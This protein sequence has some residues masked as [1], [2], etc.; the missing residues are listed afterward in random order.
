MYPN[1]V[2]KLAITSSRVFFRRSPHL[3]AAPA[4]QVGQWA[5]LDNKDYE[6]LHEALQGNFESLLELYVSKA[7]LITGDVHRL[8]NLHLTT[9]LHANITIDRYAGREWYEVPDV[10]HGGGSDAGT[11][12][13]DLKRPL[14]RS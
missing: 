12:D 10:W 2:L 8:H 11:I 5:L 6:D 4:C 9:M 3:V 13:I 7:G 14:S 1:I